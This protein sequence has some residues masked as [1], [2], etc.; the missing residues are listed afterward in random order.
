[1]ECIKNVNLEVRVFKYE[2]HEEREEHIRKMEAEGFKAHA[3][4]A[5]LKSSSLTK[6]YLNK[7]NWHL[8]AEF[9]R[10]RKESAPDLPYETD[11]YVF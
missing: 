5:M 4:E 8:V 7:E 9:S 6:D 10:I 2:S 1:M 3:G 11:T